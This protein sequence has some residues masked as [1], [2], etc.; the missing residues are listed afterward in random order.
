M[1]FTGLGHR[2]FA[3]GV[4]LL[5]LLPFVMKDSAAQVVRQVLTPFGYRDADKVHA[6]PNGYELVSLPDKQ[7]RMQNPTTGDHVDF[8]APVAM[9]EGRLPF[10]DS[11]WITYA[12][13]YNTNRRPVAYFSTDWYVPY[14]PKTYHG[15]T[16]FQFNSIEPAS[17]DAILQP[18][19]QYGPS[20]AGGGEYWAV[21]SW[22][23][24]GNQAYFTTLVEVQKNQFLG[25]Q[26]TLIGKQRKL[27]S[28]TCDFYGINGTTLTINNIA[29]LVWCTETLEVY[30]VTECTE[31]PPEAYSEMFTITI[32]LN[33][34]EAPPSMGWTVTNA[35][36]NC[37]T[38]TAVINNGPVNG[39][40]YIYY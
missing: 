24:V 14:P 3:G 15:Q 2:R 23:V 40:V 10:T 9:N 35:Q 4:L 28:Y 6:V 16:L 36:T 22:Y 34:G 27:C 38:Q 17:G 13:W 31:F 5:L 18:V 7:I 25:G 32:D 29:E 11:G 39:T 30:G 21:A 37:G 33:T 12:S 19:L 8:P 1:L 20:A 26:I